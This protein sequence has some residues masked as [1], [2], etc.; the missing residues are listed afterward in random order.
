MKKLLSIFCVLVLIAALLC[1]CV[2]EEL[3][4]EESHPDATTTTALTTFSTAPTTTVTQTATETTAVTTQDTTTGV[5]ATPSTTSVTTVVTVTV[6][7]TGTGTQTQPEQPPIIEDK[8]P[9]TVE[10]EGYS[11]RRSFGNWAVILAYNGTEKEV[12]VPIPLSNY[13]ITN[14]S[15]NI[16]HD[17]PVETVYLPEYSEDWPYSPIELSSGRR[18]P[19][20]K[21]LSTFYLP[22]SIDKYKVAA[23]VLRS[24][25]FWSPGGA[26]E[27]HV[28]LPKTA[29][30]DCSFVEKH[31]SH[32]TEEGDTVTYHM[33][34]SYNA[35]GE[36]ILAP[37]T[38][39]LHYYE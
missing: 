16:Y 38:F 7:Q 12:Q 2:A 32:I 5:T 33:T 11:V 28:Y 17:S 39:T 4:E 19:Y 15:F 8:F 20:A 13:I 18:N 30:F 3:P 35:A 34:G 26:P 10:I 9:P 22:R 37:T 29:T 21:T 24:E 1:G 23:G 31:C 14:F 25:M 6:T 27:Q 36:E